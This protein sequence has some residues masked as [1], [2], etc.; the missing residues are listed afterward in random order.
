MTK[1]KK[2]ELVRFFTGNSVA[3]MSVMLNS[4]FEPE[5][6]AAAQFFDVR[7]SFGITGYMDFN[8]AMEAFDAN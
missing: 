6:K 7:G 5:R 4:N 2:E 1:E 3:I 8:T